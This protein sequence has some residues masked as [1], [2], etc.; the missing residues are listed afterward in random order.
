MKY[1]LIENGK[2]AQTQPGYEDGFVEV[3]ASVVCGMIKTDEGFV[4]PEPVPKSIQEQINE[5]ER[6]VTPRN[7]RDYVLGDQYAIDKIN[8]VEADIAILRAKL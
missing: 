8:K 3:D 1:A 6:S 5:L 2:V 7:Y 4:N